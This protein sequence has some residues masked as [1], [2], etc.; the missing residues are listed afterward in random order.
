[1]KI[2][3]LER[4]LPGTTAESFEPHLEAEARAVWELMQAGVIREIHFRQDR[5]EAVILMEAG[6]T[7]QAK[8]ALAGLPLVQAGLIEF[9]VIG[10]QPYP[11]F[12]R[13]FK[14]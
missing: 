11:G 6:S 7:Q 12:A 5:S 10:L 9:E 2:L 8:E 3:A 4:D 13:L 1:M 14:A